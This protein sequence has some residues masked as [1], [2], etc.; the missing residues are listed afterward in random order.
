LLLETRVKSGNGCP[1]T[2]PTFAFYHGSLTMSSA[3]GRQ[4]DRK[5]A[6]VVLAGGIV[7][8]I[9]SGLGLFWLIPAQAGSSNN[10]SGEILK[11]RHSGR[12]A[13]SDWYTLDRDGLETYVQ[14]YAAEAV[15]REGSNKQASSL[16]YVSISQYQVE[17]NCEEFGGEKYCFYDYTPVLGFLGFG[18]VANSELEV[19]RSLRSASLNTEVQ[20]F[21]Y[22]TGQ[23]MTI[24]VDADWTGYGETYKGKERYA[25][26]NQYYRIS[27]H[28]IGFSK[29]AYASADI[30]G[31]IELN[32]GEGEYNQAS[33]FKSNVGFMEVIKGPQL[34]YPE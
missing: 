19:A 28:S 13:V 6:A 31:D 14:I 21:D 17:E 24:T 8:S 20:G 22:V 26:S 32:L 7:F 33:V 25:S 4:M 18:E 2:I 3:N 16:A 5:L 15:S 27:E 29:D 23:E 34:A 30:S 1:G 12:G 11:Y 10:A 9:A